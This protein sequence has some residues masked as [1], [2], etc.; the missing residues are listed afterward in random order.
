MSEY[1]L[2]LFLV[3][4]GVMFR[5][6]RNGQTSDRFLDAGHHHHLQ[7]LAANTARPQGGDWADHNRRM[8]AQE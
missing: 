1:I 7:I 8:A 2:L 5:R 3:A 4:L 6:A